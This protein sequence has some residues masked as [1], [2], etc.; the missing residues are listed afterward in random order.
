MNFSLLGYKEIILENAKV[1]LG[2]GLSLGLLLLVF[3]PTISA[4]PGSISKRNEQ[5]KILG[6]LE[7]KSKKINSLLSLSQTIKT[8]VTLVDKALPS[9]D[10]VPSLMTQIQA[11][12]TESGV[13]LKALQFGGISKMPEK[14]Y[15]KIILQ[16]VLEGG[17]ANI[18]KD[19]VNLEKTSR[20][21]NV[22]S[23]SFDSRKGEGVLSV[24]LGL[25]SF[26]LESGESEFDPL[27]PIN[28]NLS[29]KGVTQIIDFIKTLKIY[30]PQVSSIEVGRGNPFE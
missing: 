11:I 17:Y 19:L 1:I 8:D 27:A 15:K 14:I 9:K 2:L 29:D 12:A 21:I 23:V 20:I 26:F 3:L 24:S 18:L 22:E 7:E 16:A 5:E 25:A 28:L 4:L 6:L 13:T 30:E 10:E